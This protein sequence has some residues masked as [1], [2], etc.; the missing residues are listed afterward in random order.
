MLTDWNRQ[1]LISFVIA[2][3]IRKF[4]RLPNRIYLINYL[5]HYLI[6][7][8]LLAWGIILVVGSLSNFVK[9]R[10]EIVIKR[11]KAKV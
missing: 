2:Y 8:F 6:H 7:C 5:I 9:L 11:E 10:Y 1:S 4:T 3:H